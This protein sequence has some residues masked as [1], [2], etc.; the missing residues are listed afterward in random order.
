MGGERWKLGL[1]AAAI[2]LVALS[3]A[4]ARADRAPGGD[5]GL[6]IILGQPTGLTLEFFVA[7]SQSIDLAI[8]LDAFNRGGF[9]VH[10]DY[11]F[12]LPSLV[13][14]RSVSLSPYLG[15]G[16]FV[17]GGRPDVGVRVPFG[18]S[19]DFRTAPLKLFLEVAPHLRLVDDVRLRI[20]AA[21]GFRYFF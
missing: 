21:V 8:G 14:G 2:L 18:L 9:Y 16:V 17:A 6:G 15:P 20:A 13:R 12:Y 11:L 5:F 3:A 19:L 10:G 4:P 7:S 1:A